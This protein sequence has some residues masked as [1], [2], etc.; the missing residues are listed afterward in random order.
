MNGMYPVAG[1]QCSPTAKT[2]TMI[3]AMTN[4]GRASMPKVPVVEMLSRA[5]L[6]R[7]E[8][9]RASGMAT[10]KA[11]TWEMMISSSVDGP[12]RWR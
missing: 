2:A 11:M 12:T 8:V 3:G 5:R 7:R 9:T 10:T 1:N 4:G 6:G